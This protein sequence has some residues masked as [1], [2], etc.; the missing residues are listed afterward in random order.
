MFLLWKRKGGMIML[1]YL[2]DSLYIGLRNGVEFYYFGQGCIADY[3]SNSIA[4]LN[5]DDINFILKCDGNHRLSD[6]LS[7]DQQL[8]QDDIS[9]IIC[10]LFKKGII[11]FRDKAFESK[12]I[13]HGIKGLYYPKE[14]AIELTSTC[15]YHCPFCY[16]NALSNGSFI[17]DDIVNRINHIIHGNVN[18]ILLTGGEPTIHPN[19]SRYI[20]LFS[21]YAN[22]HMITNGSILYEQDPEAFKKLQVIQFSI[23]GCDNNEYEKMTGN[24]KGF[25]YLCKSVEFAKRNN[26]NVKGAVTLCDATIDHIELFIKT[27]IDF[28][29]KI[30]RIG[31]ADIF[32]RGKYLYRS[33]SNFKSS[34]N[35]VLNSII[36]LKRKYRSKIQIELPNIT[37]HHVSS[38]DDIFA[39]V[40]RESLQCGCGSEYLAISHIG[41]IRPCQMLPE[42]WF[43][44]KDE[45]ALEE[46]IHGNFHIEQLNKSVKKYYVENNFND[47]NISPCYALETFLNK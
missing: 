47:L 31:I 7:E 35:E 45:N 34:Q 46:H 22:V 25:T 14:I 36:E 16:K 15:N 21:D 8:I 12:I 38:H 11:V 19:I 13:F 41:E 17:T 4:F 3:Y 29:F 5:D 27:A 23:Y 30:L 18:N 26:I 32:G 43:S 40:Y 1:D 33:D 10:E 44:I 20:E 9:S 24:N 6:L 2:D 39:G 42:R 28:G 37:T